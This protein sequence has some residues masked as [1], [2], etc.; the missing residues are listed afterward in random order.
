MSAVSETLTKDQLVVGMLAVMGGDRQEVNERDLFLA[1]WH[2]F[3][4]AMRWA[5]TALPNPD[6]FTASL[7]RLDAD[8]VILRIGK[9]NRSRRKRSTRRAFLEA[10]RSG[11][12]KARV[13]EGGLDRTGVTPDHLALIRQ[14]APSPESYMSLEPAVL[15][16]ICIGARGDEGRPTDEG[17]LV[18]AAFHKF[19]AVFAY[20]RRPEFPDVATIV[21]AVTE[22]RVR[23]LI[24]DDFALTEA[25]RREIKRHRA[26]LDVRLDASESHKTGVF[27]LADRIESSPSYKAYRENGTLALTKADEL[28]RALRLPPTT[29]PRPVATALLGRTK[30][31]RRVDKVEL[32]EYLLKV[33]K[34][35]NP[36]VV[37][38]VQEDERLTAALV[39]GDVKGGD[40]EA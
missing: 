13:K 30:D 4:N 21:S 23:G 22:A 40:E 31:L 18:E 39:A 9:Q 37:A 32:V 24:T 33:A 2:A 35:H 20:R 6:T 15:V 1:C 34:V 26:T 17:A 10:G 25:G 11:V 7:R 3:P 5:D 16:T 27:K 29:D 28:F 38:L 36:E 19:P 12:V 14:L 8:G